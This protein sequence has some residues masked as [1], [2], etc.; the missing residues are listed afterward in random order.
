VL[1][2]L[3]VRRVFKALLAQPALKVFRVLLEM[4]LVFLEPL[5]L[6]A[7]QVLRE[8]KVLQELKEFKVLQDL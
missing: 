6:Q 2:V 7:Q 4:E 1:P 3:Q 5:A 8:F